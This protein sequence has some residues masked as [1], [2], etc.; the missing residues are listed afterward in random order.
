MPGTKGNK[1]YIVDEE[2]DTGGYLTPKQTDF[3]KFRRN[4][5]MYLNLRD[6][7]TEKKE[8]IHSTFCLY[9]HHSRQK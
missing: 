3:L 7:K 9:E 8:S 1:K 6:F 5:K 2:R 4:G